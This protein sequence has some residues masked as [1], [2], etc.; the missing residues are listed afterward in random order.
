MRRAEASRSL[1]HSIRSRRSPFGWV[2]TSKAMQVAAAKNILKDIMAQQPQ[3]TGTVVEPRHSNLPIWTQASLRTA[4]RVTITRPMVRTALTSTTTVLWT[5]ALCG[6]VSRGD[7]EM[8]PLTKLRHIRNF[9]QEEDEHKVIS[10]TA[11][12]AHATTRAP[13]APDGESQS[14]LRPHHL[15]SQMDL[16]HVSA[17]KLG[18][19]VSLTCCTRTGAAV[20]HLHTTTPRGHGGSPSTSALLTMEQTELQT[21]PR[22]HNR[23]APRT[24]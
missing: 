8:T 17:S 15:W 18:R 3:V 4:Q 11:T 1:A 19:R 14:I 12:R 9:L 20:L 10:S 16:S 5:L 2:P 7:W 23:E 22:R 24:R 6:Y 13:H 21:S